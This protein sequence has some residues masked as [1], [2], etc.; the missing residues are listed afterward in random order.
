MRL[1]YLILAH[2]EPEQ[3]F[4]LISRLS[5]EGTV[6]VIHFCKNSS[7]IVFNEI[8]SKYFGCKNIYF[9]KREN[10]AWGEF[11]IVKAVFDSIKLLKEKKINYDYL[12]VISAQDYPL[13]SNEYIKKYF[14]ENYGKQF[15]RFWRMLPDEN[16]EYSEEQTWKGFGVRRIEK[17]RMKISGEYYYIPDNHYMP[18]D[19]FKN[20]KIFIFE[21]PQ[22]IKEKTLKTDS[23][24]FIL[25]TVFPKH[26]KFPGGIEPYGGSQWWSITKDCAEYILGFYN[27]NKRLVEFY[28]QTLLSDEMFAATCL[29]NSDYKN[30]VIND[31]LRHIIFKESSSHPKTYTTKDFD[32]LKNSGK[33]FARKFEN[34]I[35]ENI[36]DLIDKNILDK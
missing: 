7:D 24:N 32:E 36:F 19:F 30:N 2:K 35:D 8:K 11:G 6:F 23:M 4:R 29:M 12:N 27:K 33:L 31:N 16:C 13:K 25:S 3:L 15:V 34:T 18:H 5:S 22:K 20:L 26:R 28:K 14:K 1:V 9:C 10:G 21:I 17:R